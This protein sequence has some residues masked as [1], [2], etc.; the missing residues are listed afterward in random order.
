[1]TNE[2]KLTALSERLKDGIVEKVSSGEYSYSSLARKIGST[3]QAVRQW[4]LGINNVR[5]DFVKPLAL[6]LGKSESWARSGIGEENE[7]VNDSII[8]VPVIDVKASAGH[9]LMIFE[10][11]VVKNIELDKDWLRSNCHF[12]CA[13]K[14]S[15]ITASGDSMHPTI[16]NGDFLL[17]DEGVNTIR[18]DSIYVAVVNDSLYVK[19]FQKTPRNTLL[20]ISDNSAYERFELDPDR[21]D[22]RVIGKVIYH[23]HGEKR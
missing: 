2:K 22:V 3:P 6:A 9:G 1:M 15:V 11:Q 23:W 17:V 13:N 14:L 4:A 8:S 20:M 16:D 12:T 5:D 19:R 7:V 10:E 21:D 18:T